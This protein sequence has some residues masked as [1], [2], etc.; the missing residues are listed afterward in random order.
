MNKVRRREI[1]DIVEGLE[2]TRELIEG[3]M[4]QEREYM[5]NMPENL[6]YGSQRWSVAEDA[7]YDL[8]CACEAFDEII[9]HLDSAKGDE[10]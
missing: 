8:E 3:V 4:E 7:V 5:E 1:A 9:G 6:Q 2:R 10:R